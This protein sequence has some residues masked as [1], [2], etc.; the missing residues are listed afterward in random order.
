MLIKNLFRYWTYQVFFPG[1]VLREKYEAFKTLL[2]YDKAAHEFMATLEEIYY[3]PKKCDFQAVV[4]NYDQFSHA[5][6][7]MVDALL[8]ICPSR[9]WSLKDYYKKFDF[10]NRFMLAPPEFE[11]SPP[12]TISFDKAGSFGEAVAGNKAFCLS[13]I[14]RDLHLPTPKGF[15]IT[16]QAFHYFMET[17][18][19]RHPINERLACLDISDTS[20]LERISRE[21]EALILN[22]DVPED[23][24]MAVT[25]A[26]TALDSGNGSDLR[27]ALRSSA[28]K[29]DGK[30]SF[31]GQYQTLLN[32]DKTKILN[33]YKRV[34]A[35]K[36]SASA[37]FYRISQGIL[38]DETPMAVLV[39]E[40]VDSKAAG[41]LYTVD[42][43]DLLSENLMIHSVQ[44][45]GGKLVEGEAVP[46][47]ITVS[48]KDLDHIVS[49]TPAAGAGQ[50][51]FDAQIQP[52]KEGQHPAGKRFFLDKATVLTLARWGMLLETHFNC[53]QDIE[54]CQ[55]NSGK[56]FVL[57][58]RPLNSPLKSSL[59]KTLTK[60]CKTAKPY[61]PIENK[62]LCSGAESVCPGIGCGK[63]YRLNQLSGLSQVP[64][65]SVLVVEHASPQMVTAIHK[66]AAIIIG[67]GSRA[68]H[69]SSIAREFGVPAIANVTHGFHDLVQGRRVTVDADRGMVYDGVAVSLTEKA[70]LL[71]TDFFTDSSFMAKLRYVINFSAKLKLTDPGSRDF[72]PEGCRSL[73][74]IIRFAHETAVKEMFLSGN[75]KG[76]RKKGAKKLIF[77]VPMLF[78]VLD[79][80]RGI[81]PDQKDKKNIRPEDISSIPMQAVLKGLCDPG[82]CWSETT[83]FDWES[84]DKIVMAGGIISADDAQFGSYA[85]V[86][87]KYLNVNFRFGYHF[88]ILDTMCSS[89][90]QDN[91]I[92]FRFSGGGGTSAGRSLRA[93]FIKG[94]LTRLGFMV[95][96]K[97][98][99]IDAEFK[100]GSLP[101]MKKTLDTVGRLL[102]ATKLMDMYLKENMDMTCLIDEFMAGR[103]D[104]RSAI[105]K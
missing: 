71:K 40:M 87:K 49:I 103:Y 39:L 97:S 25:D 30:A 72:K 10:Y 67:R 38:D 15:V 91:Y 102:G 66:V 74:D 95:E 4:K 35:S 8:S 65:G 57:Q 76:S 94:V 93:G 32:V 1:T 47:V 60:S 53:P 52:G 14:N 90:E 6:S 2:E 83:H 68:S 16:T 100:N 59:N 41:V 50:I 9:Y 17:N 64:A 42:M 54:W 55:D 101:T 98:D 46:D 7:G 104:F 34:I 89:C 27:V 70:A 37:L 86:S 105:N 11:F 44:G 20:S 56:L 24:V 13:Q 62:L 22:A 43:D 18:D 21:I 19:L 51:I 63:V 36:Y 61:P 77:P 75:R 26:V 29:E 88:V 99:L 82:I 80:G 96:I 84:Y 28:V 81:K 69:F 33:G 58:S 48:K 31:A 12:F 45:Q 85:V 3:T 23:I 78:Y 73:H 79:V 5:V 92:L